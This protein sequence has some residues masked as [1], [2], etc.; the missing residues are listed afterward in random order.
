MLGDQDFRVVLAESTCQEPEFKL[1]QTL[2][3]GLSSVL[4]QIK[5]LMEAVGY[6]I[7]LLVL[8]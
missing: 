1:A 4:Y 8:D 3:F 5:S 7:S 6:V 2:L